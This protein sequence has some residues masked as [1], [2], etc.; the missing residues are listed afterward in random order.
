MI[1]NKDVVFPY[2][3]LTNSDNGYK[4][5]SFEFD[6]HRLIDNGSQYIFKIDFNIRSRFISNLVKEGKA[7]IIFIIRS[8]DNYFVRLQENQKEIIIPKSKLS[9]LSK[10]VVQ[11]HIQ[12]LEE[13]SMFECKELSP[14]YDQYK[15]EIKLAKHVLL[16]YSNTVK[17]TGTEYNS[18][19]LFHKSV[20]TNYKNAFEV[21]LNESTILLK[22]NDNKYLTSNNSTKNLLNMYIYVGLSRALN[23]FIVNN[24]NDNEEFIDL[25]SLDDLQMTKLDSKLLSLMINKGILEIDYESIDS[26]ISKIS[27]NIIEKYANSI[28]RVINNGS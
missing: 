21:E 19:E 9:L 24:N 17:Y 16:G 6:V 2:P 26:V 5:S 3:I 14:F 12:T 18:L 23:A 4:N 10:T 11:L 1:Y 8:Q 22:F 13:I 27:N 28:E 7:A 20:D 15:D 25:E